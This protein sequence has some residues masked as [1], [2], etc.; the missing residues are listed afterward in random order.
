[1]TVIDTGART[2]PIRLAPLFS[3][4]TDWATAQIHRLRAALPP[5]SELALL[6]LMLGLIVLWASAAVVFGYPAIILPAL[7][8]VPTIAVTLIVITWG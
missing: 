6:A 3:P 1:M 4:L 8:L 2:R 7:A 5:R